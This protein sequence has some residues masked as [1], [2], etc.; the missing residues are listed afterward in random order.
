MSCCARAPWPYTNGNS[1]N[2]PETRPPIDWVNPTTSPTAPSIDVGTGGSISAP[3]SPNANFL[4]FGFGSPHA[5]TCNI[6]LADGS[7]RPI[8]KSINPQILS[9]LATIA[10][11]E[12][13]SDDY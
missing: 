1:Q 3:V 5:D 4:I 10:G 8:S 6:G 11:A 12:K 13:V 2:F 9:A 7:A